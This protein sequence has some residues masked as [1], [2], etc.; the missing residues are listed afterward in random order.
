MS[1]RVILGHLSVL[2]LLAL[3]VPVMAQPM[4]ETVDLQTVLT[5]ARTSSPRVEAEEQD[6]AGAGKN[7]FAS[8][9]VSTDHKYSV[10]L[11]QKEGKEDI[12]LNADISFVFQESSR[13]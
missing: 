13:G 3:S 7:E 10:W 11:V 1:R 5:L 6:I 12:L 4:P 2:P 8:V 9:P